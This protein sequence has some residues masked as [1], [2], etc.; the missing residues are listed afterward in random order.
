MEN[1]ERIE[2]PIY[3]RMMIDAMQAHIKEK[4]FDQL[5]KWLRFCEWV[6]SHGNS[7]HEPN[8]RGNDKPREN[9]N[10][11]K[12]R[13]VVVDF[14][15]A[16]LKE[17]VNVPITTRGQLAKLLEMLCTQFDWRLDEN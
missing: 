11:S 7:E 15:R 13:Q 1:R 16:C 9:P 2:R 12:A 3:V 8:Y 14:I 17:D 6:L 4:N 10:W 5:N